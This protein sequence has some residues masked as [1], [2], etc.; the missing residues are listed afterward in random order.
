[1][2]YGL[3]ETQRED[4]TGFYVPK[5]STQALNAPNAG[6]NDLKYNRCGT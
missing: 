5:A 4:K 6:L 1:V 3:V 2:V